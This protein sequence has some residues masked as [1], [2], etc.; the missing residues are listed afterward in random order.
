MHSCSTNTYAEPTPFVNGR[1]PLR[2]HSQDL[3]QFTGWPRRKEKGLREQQL[4][5][6]ASCQKTKARPVPRRSTLLLLFLGSLL[7]G[8][9]LCRHSVFLLYVEPSP[10]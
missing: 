7:R 8:F 3:S 4:W 1:T 10:S 2:S 6:P 9:L 5:R